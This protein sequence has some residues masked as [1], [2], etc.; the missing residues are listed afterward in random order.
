MDKLSILINELKI[1]YQ[2]SFNKII[3]DVSIESALI[4]LLADD[5][6]FDWEGDILN[7]DI[8]LNKAWVYIQEFDFSTLQ[9]IVETDYSFLPSE[10]IYSKKVRIKSKGI[11]W[12]IHKND[13]DPFPS[14]P[15]AH[16]LG[17]NIK[18]DLSNGKCYRIRK[19]INTISKKD[20]EIIRDKALKVFKGKL[21]DLEC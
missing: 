19:Y 9:N 15:H 4:I 13:K 5:Y 1:K 2:S 16:Y 21:P 11:I 8:S 10:F 18:L 20:L 12:V 7:L 17:G 3:D 6:K 14:S